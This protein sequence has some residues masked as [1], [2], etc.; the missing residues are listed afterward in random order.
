MQDK[1][2]L[3]WLEAPLQSWGGDSKFGNRDTLKFPT[4]S[5]IAGLLLCAMGA[6]GEQIELLAKLKLSRQ[7]VISYRKQPTSDKES[8]A[9]LLCDFHM[10]GSGYDKNHAWQKMM[11]PKTAEGKAAVGGGSKMTYRHYLQDACFAVV[12]TTSENLAEQFMQALQMPVF[13]IYLGKK[14]CVPTDFIPRGVF[15]SEDEAKAEAAKI[16]HAKA[17]TEEFW[18]ID[19]EHPKLGEPF[20]VNDVPVRFGEAKIYSDRRAT[21]IRSI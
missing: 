9:P 10:V 6:S 4:R 14:C 18:V 15:A 8:S 13:D 5:G 11:I 17:R 21:I 1:S 2:L 20:S 7:T 19:G 12:L 3:M 16:A